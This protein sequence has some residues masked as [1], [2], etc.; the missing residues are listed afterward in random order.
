V[1]ARADLVKT[2]LWEWVDDPISRAF[3]KRLGIR[4]VPLGAPDVLPSLST[5]MVDAALGT[6]LAV[7]ALQ[8][9]GHVKYMTSL[10]FGQAIGATVITRREL[11]RLT[12]AQQKIVIDDAR[13][14]EQKLLAQVRAENDRALAALRKNG[15]VVVDSPPSLAHELA[16]L[17]E[18]LRADLEP[19]L[20]SHELRARVEELVASYRRRHLASK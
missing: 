11:D 1:R 3:F 5:G 10:H 13:V 19:T 18:P 2:K 12:P 15:L 8:W 20:Y 16:E 4:G 17:A 9:H 14:L 7:M 6:P